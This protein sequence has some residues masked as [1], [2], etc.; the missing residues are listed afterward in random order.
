MN[1]IILLDLRSGRSHPV[2]AGPTAIGRS[3]KSDVCLADRNASRKHAILEREDDFVWITDRHSRKGT[4]VNGERLKGG[5]RWPLRRLDRLSFGSLLHEFLIEG[6]RSLYETT[7]A[8]TTE[9]RDPGVTAALTPAEGANREFG[10]SAGTINFLNEDIGLGTADQLMRKYCPVRILKSGGMGKIYL[11]QERLS[12]R[13][14]AHKVMHDRLVA[15]IPHVH[16]FVREAVITARMQHPNI[17]PV[18]DLG[19][20]QGNQ[21]YYT[22]RYVEGESFGRLLG[23]VPLGTNLAILRAAARAVDHAHELGLWHRDMKPENIP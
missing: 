3:P 21:L 8:A 18:H 17:I 9:P 16:Q 23:H 19:F 13:I 5:V 15:S 20:I 7:C 12:G 1:N 22:M 10:F 4:Y 14:V 6:N 2:A 11:V